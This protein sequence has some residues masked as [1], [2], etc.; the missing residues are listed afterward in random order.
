ME[1]ER[2]HGEPWARGG[3]GVIEPVGRDAELR[4]AIAGVGET[5]RVAG[6]GARV[7]P[8]A[9][10]P[11]GS[12]SA[13]PLDLADA[14]EVDPDRM[15]Q[16]HVEVALG[17]VRAGVADLRR[18]PAVGERVVDL[19]RRARVDPDAAGRPGRAEPAQDREHARVGTGLEREAG[20]GP[21]R[22]PGRAPPAARGP[23][24]AG[25]PGPRRTAACRACGRVP[26]GRRRRASAG[27]RRH[28]GPGAATR[29]ARGRAAQATTRSSG[30]LGGAGAAGGGRGRGDR[31]A[32]GWAGGEDRATRDRIRERVRPVGHGRPDGEQE[33]FGDGGDLLDRAAERL[34]VACGRL[35]ESAH[36]AD[37]LEGGRAGP[38]RSWPSRCPPGGGA[39]G[40]CDTCRAA[41]CAGPDG[42]GRDLPVV[43]APE[44]R[45][46]AAARLE[47]VPG[48]VVATRSRSGAEMHRKSW[49][50]HMDISA[51]MTDAVRGQYWPGTYNAHLFGCR[52]RRILRP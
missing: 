10:G 29:S 22:R 37:V 13:H 1:V 31:S 45:R 14:V 33:P 44:E 47:R 12:A 34:G 3:D 19:A 2:V 18:L 42:R 30:D 43:P 28:P 52:P 24:R 36:L 15:R 50:L 17:H 41:Y 4:R 48:G 25:G 39:G 23:S 20:H 6:A 32:R 27:R 38:H 35:A 9:D 51:A 40:C 26:R 46:G 16:E 21:G 7:D 8:D 49:R 11:T 5:L